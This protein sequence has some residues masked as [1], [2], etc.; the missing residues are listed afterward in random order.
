MHRAYSPKAWSIPPMLLR[1]RIK[2]GNKPL[3]SSTP[4]R[5]ETYFGPDI[6]FT[7]RDGV[8][9]IHFIYHIYLQIQL[10]QTLCGRCG[11]CFCKIQF[12]LCSVSIFTYLASRAL[13]MPLQGLSNK[14]RQVL[15]L[16]KSALMRLPCQK[17]ERRIKEKGS[18]PVIVPVESLLYA[19]RN[20][21]FY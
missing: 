7:C 6:F 8:F 1:S 21:L 3:F 9:I 12:I 18:H 5:S 11:R 17:N 10:R 16:P 4:V 19:C 2:C 15:H 13:L 14:T 20:R